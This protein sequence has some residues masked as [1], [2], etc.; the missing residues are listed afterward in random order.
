MN[1]SRMFASVSQRGRRRAAR[2]YDAPMS[3]DWPLASDLLLLFVA[4]VVLLGGG[5][6]LF[7]WAAR[8]QERA[9][10]AQLVGDVMCAVSNVQ[11][12]RRAVRGRVV[13][14]EPGRA[15][16]SDAHGA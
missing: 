16:M 6:L 2:S 3:L 4:H 8:R 7:G 15:V 5:A 1:S 10:V 11:P 9:R 14:V 12:G 13:V